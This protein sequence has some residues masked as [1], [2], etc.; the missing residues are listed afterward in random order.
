M[1]PTVTIR[2][3][4]PADLPAL[5]QVLAAQQPHS[6]Y[7]MRWPLPYPVED[8]IARPDEVRAWTAT[9]DGRPVGHV[10]TARV[11]SDAAADPWAAA[12]R[13]PVERL[14]ALSVLFVDHEVTGSGVGRLLHDT[15]VAAIRAEGCRPVL[16]V[17]AGHSPAV[18]VYEHL[19]WRT[20]GR[21]RPAW[22][23]EGA[24]PVLLMELP[25]AAG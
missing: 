4:T 12:L 1:A 5:A 19:G 25:P 2:D 9:L 17:V 15:A 3:R 22:L 14:R 23:P 20:V 8:F 21:A 13:Q 6:H 24:P 10:A 11:G 16:D 7:P 18:E